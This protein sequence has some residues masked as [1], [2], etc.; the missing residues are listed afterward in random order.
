M[1][2]LPAPAASL[3]RPPDWRVLKEQAGSEVQEK[4]GEIEGFETEP[5]GA[6]VV[7]LKGLQDKQATKNKNRFMDKCIAA[8]IASRMERMSDTERY[9]YKLPLRTPNKR[10]TAEVI[11]FPA[12]AKSGYAHTLGY[13][14][15]ESGNNYPRVDAEQRRAG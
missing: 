14:H 10:P 4:I 15:A 8:E 11:P 5:T 2:K 13:T 3:E 12:S 7:I 6:Q 9:E 1:E